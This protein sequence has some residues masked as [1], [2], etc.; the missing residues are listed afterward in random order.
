MSNAAHPG[1]ARLNVPDGTT[2]GDNSN[3]SR[4]E[5][6]IRVTQRLLPFMWQEI[7]Q[8]IE[9]TLYAATSPH[10]EGA[11][12][13]TPRGFLGAT[14]GGVREAAIPPQTKNEADAERLWEISERLTGVKYPALE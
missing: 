10:A 4:P 12:L 13:Y 1:M 5:R 6:F 2:P 11:A 9:P 14:G 3:V 7:E 8:A